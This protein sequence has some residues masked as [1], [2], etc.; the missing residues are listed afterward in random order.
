MSSF[1]QLCRRLFPREQ[2]L[3]LGGSFLVHLTCLVVLAGLALPI[4]SARVDSTVINHLIDTT[5][6]SELAA[7]LGGGDA[8]LSVSPSEA[9]GPAGREESF[10][11]AL[12]LAEADSLPFADTTQPLLA[13]RSALATGALTQKVGPGTSRGNGQGTADFGRGDGK[14]GNGF[15]NGSGSD[16]FGVKG[17]GNNVVFVVDASRSMYYPHPGPAVNRFG[18]VKLELLRTISQMT[19]SQRFFIIFF[20]DQP[21]PMPA[22]RL[23]E[24]TLSSKKRYLEWMVNVPAAKGTIPDGALLLALR[25]RPDVIYFLTDGNFEKRVVRSITEANL[26]RVPI[27]TIG[28]GDDVGEEHLREIATLNSGRYKFISAEEEQ[29]EADGPG[30]SKSPPDPGQKRA[31]S[32][33]V[34]SP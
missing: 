22:E 21:L 31:R 24:A 23:M 15:G 28:F 5:V 33:A 29:A 26:G 27:H 13:S 14:E 12:A 20:N 6:T 9:S 3:S 4:A 30:E 8:V 18:R 2:L 16:F 7:S 19:E 17:V 32:K 11:A 1:S 34:E 25:L 10:L